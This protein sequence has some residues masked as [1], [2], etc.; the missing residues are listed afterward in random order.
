MNTFLKIKAQLALYSTLL[1][2]AISNRLSLRAVGDS[3]EMRYEF[4]SGEDSSRILQG[5]DTAQFCG[6]ISTFLQKSMLAPVSW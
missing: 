3:Y 4:Y 5:C 1:P 6:R 2:Q